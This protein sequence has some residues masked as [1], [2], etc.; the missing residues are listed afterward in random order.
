MK[1]K[2]ENWKI[3]NMALVIERARTSKD[4]FYAVSP[5]KNIRSTDQNAYYWW[6]LQLIQ[7]H[8]GIDKEE[9][10]EKMKMQ[11]LSVA[12]PAGQLPYCR[13]TSKLDTKEF[14]DYIENVKNFMAER[15]GL[16]LPSAEE[17]SNFINNNI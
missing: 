7:D 17:R 4:W 8:T 1:I 12:V 11:Y 15:I 13:S 3:I 9:I 2:V 5:W 14:T 16:V 6:L 10:H